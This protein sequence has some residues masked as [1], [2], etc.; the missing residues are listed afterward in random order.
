MAAP[1]RA[2]QAR[3]NERAP[4]ITSDRTIL[5]QRH[6]GDSPMVTAE[7]DIVAAKR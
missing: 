3:L 7:T 2:M 4:A 1:S 6:R 5:E